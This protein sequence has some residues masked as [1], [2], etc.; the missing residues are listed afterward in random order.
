[1]ISSVTDYC[2]RFCTFELI[3]T[4]KGFCLEESYRDEIG[5]NLS[6]LHQEKLHEIM[7]CVIYV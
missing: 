6:L 2:G 1:M 7:N 3:I 5:R 4:E